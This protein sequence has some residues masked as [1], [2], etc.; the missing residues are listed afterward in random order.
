MLAGLDPVKD[1]SYYLA[2]IREFN[3]RPALFP[4]GALHKSEVKRLAHELELPVADRKESMG[5]CFVGQKGNFKEFLCE[6]DFRASPYE[7][8][9]VSTASQVP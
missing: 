8:A 1:Q 4:L 5:I 6:H 2:S 9:D 7:G 3:L